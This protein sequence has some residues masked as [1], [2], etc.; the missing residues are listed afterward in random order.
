MLFYKLP[1]IYTYMHIDK[2]NSSY[3][4]WRDNA[5]PKS[6]RLSKIPVPDMKYPICQGGLRDPFP[7]KKTIQGIVI[8]LGYSLEFAGRILLLN[9]YTL[10]IGHGKFKLVLTWK[11]SSC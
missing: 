3:P 9:I 1:V 5:H 10:I 4:M 6:Y 11:H 7:P 8:A 2:L